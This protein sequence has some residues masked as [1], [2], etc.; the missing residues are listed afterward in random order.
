MMIFPHHSLHS[1]WDGEAVNNENMFLL[2]HARAFRITLSRRK[3]FRI[4]ITSHVSLPNGRRFTYCI[5]MAVSQ[6]GHFHSCFRSTVET[7]R[8]LTINSLVTV[9]VLQ[10]LKCMKRI[11]QGGSLT[12]SIQNIYLV[13][14]AVLSNAI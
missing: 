13:R 4:T 3:S 10:V 9:R 5:K 11:V 7:S 1:C 8:T 2:C 14:R 12:S 6:E